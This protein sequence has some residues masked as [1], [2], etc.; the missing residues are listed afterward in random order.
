MELNPNAKL[1]LHAEGRLVPEQLPGAA[2]PLRAIQ[3]WEALPLQQFPIYKY[4]YNIV[5]YI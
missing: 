2:V 1:L 3:R 4:K 5:L